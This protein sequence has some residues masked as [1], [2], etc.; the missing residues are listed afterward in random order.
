MS[1]ADQTLSESKN[2]PFCAETIK[3]DAVVC[4]FCGYDLRTGQ[5]SAPPRVVP[6]RETGCGMFIILLLILIGI[7]IFISVCKVVVGDPSKGEEKT[8]PF[9]ASGSTSDLA[10]KKTIEEEGT[11]ARTSPCRTTI[12]FKRFRLS[13]DSRA[14]PHQPPARRVLNIY[15]D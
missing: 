1:E 10:R 5:R 14:T 9:T 6:T 12:A 7:A 13:L 2:C 11:W 3:K 4:R 15:L 8:Y